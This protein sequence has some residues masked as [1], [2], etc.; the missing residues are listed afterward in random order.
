VETP[1]GIWRFFFCD[2]LE[3]PALHAYIFRMHFQRI[4]S[5]LAG[6]GPIVF[7][8]SRGISYGIVAGS[9]AVAAF[10]RIGTLPVTILFSL[11]ALRVLCIKNRRWL[12]ITLFSVGVVAAFFGFGL[13]AHKVVVEMPKIMAKTVPALVQ[14]ADNHGFDLPFSDFND[15][16]EAAPKIASAS[17]QYIGNFAKLAGKE[18]VMLIA[19]IA[20]ALGIFVTPPALQK[21]VEE[22]LYT[23]YDN[24]IR[25]CFD[26]FFRSFE[27]VMGAQFLISLFNTTA[28]AIFVLSTQLRP[29]SGLLIPL[30]F[31]C[32]MLPIV[33]NLISNTLIVC[34]AF[35]L[36]SP[37]MALWAL[38]FLILIHKLEYL[39]NSKIIGSR[40][41][42][43]MWLTLIALVLGNY[44]MGIPG[45][46][47]APVILNFIK[48]ECSRYAAP[49]PSRI[50]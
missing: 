37:Q 23:H 42:H 30:T 3:H 17:L 35:G 6:N 49:E 27:T 33:G 40:I 21:P 7:T 39:L 28:T 43:P 14:Y 47:L 25:G 44:L 22:N 32:G 31:I 1:G 5:E 50:G 12:A 10:L 8:R 26:S 2:C 46:I 15:L 45:V 36:I 29:Y 19:G 11:F 24:A 4:T 9:L 13:F 18:L 48:V 20:I 41:R 34:I 16:K 38:I